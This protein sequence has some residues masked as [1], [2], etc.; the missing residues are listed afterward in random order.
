MNQKTF[1][2]LYECLRRNDMQVI[3]HK[4][5]INFSEN[6]NKIFNTFNGITF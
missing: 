3:L 2:Y 6:I 5:F 4:D 1:V